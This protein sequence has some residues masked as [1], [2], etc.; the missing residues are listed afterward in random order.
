MPHR[1]GALAQLYYLIVIITIF[2]DF[3]SF[4]IIMTNDDE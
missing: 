3:D 1:Q 2:L 4:A